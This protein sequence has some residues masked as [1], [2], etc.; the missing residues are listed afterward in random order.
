MNRRTWWTALAACWLSAV[1][2]ADCPAQVDDLLT[3]SGLA[4][5][6]VQGSGQSSVRKKPTA[7]RMHVQLMAKGDNLEDALAKLKTRREAAKAQLET[8]GAEAK[9]ITFSDPSLSAAENPNRRQIE[10]MI[11]ERMAASGK[12][13]AGLKLPHTV[14]VAS[15]LKAEWPL[16][17][18]EPEKLLLAAH[19]LQEKIKAADLAGAKDAAKLSPE[20]EELA[21]EMAQSGPFGEEQA[22]PGAPQFVFV[23]KIS[24]QERREAL[25]KAFQK[26]KDH[27]TQVAEAAGAELGPLV[28]L[29]GNP[30]GGHA[31]PDGMY[32]D[33]YDSPYGRRAYAQQLMAQM[34]AEDD[35]EGA[36]PLEALGPEPGMLSYRVHVSAV[37]GL[38]KK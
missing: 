32:Y 1:W 20:E 16:A 38:K 15:F 35:G 3:R 22:E 18:E 2:A 33:P 8:L 9:S 19:K 7:L 26:A 36:P 28:M 17:A 25:A 29:S 30:G 37:F 12:K 5:Q 34:A 6:A 24:D 11:R 14:T 23:A 27:A 21:E 10:R 31:M 13:P 4:T